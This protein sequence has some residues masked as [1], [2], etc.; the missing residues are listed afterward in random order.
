MISS[1][2][3]IDIYRTKLYQKESSFNKFSELSKEQL[4]LLS[5]KV[6]K[7]Q[8]QLSEELSPILKNISNLEKYQKTIKYLTNPQ[9]HSKLKTFDER[10]AFLIM[11]T[12]PELVTYKEFLKI[13]LIS[14]SEITKA[15]DKQTRNY[16][17]EKRNKTI[18]K[19]QYLVREKI[20]F[21]DI[22]L[23][24][25]EELFFKIYFADKELI[26]EIENNNQDNLIIKAKTLK[27]FNSISNKRYEELKNIAQTWLSLTNQKYNS[28]VAAYSITNQNKLLGLTNLTEQITLFILLIDSDL[29]ML[30]IY[31]EESTQEKIKERIIEQFGYF[32]KE[33]LILERKFHDRFCP[34]KNL[35]IW[36]YTKKR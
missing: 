36:S 34:D 29:D 12:D 10:I 9:I 33:L 2:M 14:K 16:L 30:K 22:K 21:F 11:M 18:S 8:E 23:L 24:K 4:S 3:P 20:G 27:D 13:N 7:M 28:K 32:D 1:F 19:Y 26:T 31:E 15:E 17:I 35:S 25:Y 5:N 6:Y